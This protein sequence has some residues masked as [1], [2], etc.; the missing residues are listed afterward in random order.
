M[1]KIKIIFIIFSTLLFV[2]CNNNKLIEFEN[3][4]TNTNFS[5]TINITY[6]E[7]NSLNLLDSLIINKYNLIDKSKIQFSVSSYKNAD[8]RILNI[9]KGKEYNIL[10]FI[11]YTSEAGDGNPILKIITY[12]EDKIIDEI[13]FNLIYC[14]SPDIEPNQ[15]IVF[16]SNNEFSFITR[17]IKRNLDIIVNE[18][19]KVES[20]N[21]KVEKYSI[22][23]GN[24]K[25][26]S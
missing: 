12:S 9:I 17:T 10:S 24:I 3:L 8:C 4:Q 16:N 23:N 14:H 22:V 25:N 13:S 6:L 19:F 2:N 21:I 11:Y 1:K 7:H 18:E 15:F 26:A 5:D 20:D